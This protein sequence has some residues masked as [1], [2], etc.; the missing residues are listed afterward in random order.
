MTKQEIL[1]FL[2]GMVQDVKDGKE[3]ALDVYPALNELKNSVDEL[4]K[5]LYDDVIVEAEKYDRREDI[6]RRGYRITLQRQMYP[7]YSEDDE[8]S[9]INQKLKARKALIKKATEK[10]KTLTD[11]ETGETV[12]P[13][14]ATYSMFPVCEWVGEEIHG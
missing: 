12:S 1:D 4:R 2:M 5:E 9:F 8:Y 10:G 3:S 11:P 14:E 7:K 6:I 13:V